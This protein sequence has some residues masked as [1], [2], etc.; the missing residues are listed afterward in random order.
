VLIGI[1]ALAVVTI[2]VGTVALT[3]QDDASRAASAAETLPPLAAME[4]A[5]AAEHAATVRPLKVVA[6]PKKRASTS[7]SVSS[8]TAVANTSAK[9]VFADTADTGGSKMIVI[10]KSSQAVGVY[11]ATGALIDA[12]LCA[13]AVSIPPVGT[14]KVLSKKAASQSLYDPSRFY[15]FT[16]FMKSQ[17]GN[18]VGFHSIP[19]NPD[20]SLVGGL[21]APISHGCVRLEASKAKFIYDWAPIGTKVVVRR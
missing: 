15:H 10:D 21:G 16:V 1:I 13:T 7:S 19:V 3:R 20:G 14:F 18:N 11:D 17:K 2:G 8:N 9:G 5:S 6:A 12:F 4:G